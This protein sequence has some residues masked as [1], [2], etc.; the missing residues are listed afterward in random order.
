MPSCCIS[1]RRHP[2]RLFSK[3]VLQYTFPTPL[4]PVSVTALISLT[5]VRNI[6]HDCSVDDSTQ[7]HIRQLHLLQWIEEGAV[8][9]SLILLEKFIF[10]QYYVQFLDS[11]MPDCRT[12]PVCTQGPARYP[13]CVTSISYLTLAYSSFL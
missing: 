1:L 5:G 8:W 4:L 13:Y 11:L 12:V 2:F 9:F 6:S 7:S 10:G 3:F